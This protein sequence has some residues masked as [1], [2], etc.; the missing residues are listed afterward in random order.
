MF[1]N[2]YPISDGLIVHRKLKNGGFLCA[3]NKFMEYPTNERFANRSKFSIGA[4]KETGELAVGLHADSGFFNKVSSV[5]SNLSLH[6]VKAAQA[7]TVN[8]WGLRFL[9]QRKTIS[10]LKCLKQ[11]NISFVLWFSQLMAPDLVSRTA[12]S[13]TSDKL[14]RA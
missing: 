3:L 2:N 4:D 11:P 8:I 10:N 5:K 7:G 6:V 14:F 13:N 1:R 9:N 12:H